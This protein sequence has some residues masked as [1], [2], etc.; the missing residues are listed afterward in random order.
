MRHKVMVGEKNE[1][2][3]L[4]TSGELLTISVAAVYDVANDAII[5]HISACKFTIS[6]AA[7]YDVADSAIFCHL[8]A[9]IQSIARV[10]EVANSA[11][12]SHNIARYSS[13]A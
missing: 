9:C 2:G 6:V 5:C 10:L 8:S 11:I 12:T 13:I 1:E 7:V 3:A 4:E